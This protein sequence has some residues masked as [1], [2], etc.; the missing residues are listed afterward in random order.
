MAGGSSGGGTI[1]IFCKNSV[2]KNKILANGGAS[3]YGATNY[4]SNYSGAGGKGAIT[5][6]DISTGTYKSSYKNY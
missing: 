2:D 6:G 1:N 4:V 3:I 5:I